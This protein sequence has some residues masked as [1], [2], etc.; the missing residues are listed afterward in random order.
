MGLRPGSGQ[1]QFQ[2]F[3]LLSLPPGFS[4]PSPVS[5]RFFRPPDRCRPAAPARRTGPKRSVSNPAA[6]LDRWQPPRA[7]VKE[8]STP[9]AR[10]PKS[11]FRRNSFLRPP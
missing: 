6:V 11:F 4:P 10:L 2:F 8:E 5:A 3:F 1:A 7:A 9:R